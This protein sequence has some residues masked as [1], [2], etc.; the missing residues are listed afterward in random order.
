MHC[1]IYLKTLD[2]DEEK[3]HKELDLDPKHPRYHNVLKPVVI[4]GPF[5][6]ADIL[7]CLSRKSTGVAYDVNDGSVLF[8][9]RRDIEI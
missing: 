9:V 7:Y 6:P 2:S 1:S 8:P 5:F 4:S 3:V